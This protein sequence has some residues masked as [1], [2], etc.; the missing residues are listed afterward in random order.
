M[1]LNLERT[2]F[3]FEGIDG[4][5][6]TTQ[7]EE[8]AK[9]LRNLGYPVVE[10][11]S[12]SKGTIGRFIR[13][14]LRNLPKLRRNTLFLLDFLYVLRTYPSGILIWDRY[15]DSGYVSNRD[16][17]IYEALKFFSQLPLPNRTY[18]LQISPEEIYRQRA[19]SLHDHSIDLEWQ[20]FKYRR[21]QKLLQ[22]FPDRFYVIDANRDAGSI[23]NEVVTD[24]L[25]CI[26]PP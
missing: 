24:I 4:C 18:L 10:V 17:S 5:G 3:S 19:N 23:T 16:T 13:R 21:Y 9:R 20:D 8:V 2:M 7:S 12:P 14:N 22:M 1:N 26:P 15:V 6:K 25:N 11:S